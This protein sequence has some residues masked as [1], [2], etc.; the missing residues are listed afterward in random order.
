MTSRIDP[1]QYTVGWLAPMSLE[2]TPAI[3]ILEDHKEV[4][5]PDDKAIYHVGKIGPHFV[6]MAVSSMIGTAAASSVVENMCRS[7]PSIKH[8]LVVGIAGGIPHYGLDLQEQIVLGDVV[9]GV[10]L[11]NDGGVKHYEFGAWVE[12]GKLSVSGHLLHPSSTLLTAVNNLRSRHMLK[13][14]TRIPEFLHDLR[15]NIGDHELL[16]FHDPGEEHDLLFDDDYSHTYRAV[17]CEVLCDIERSRQRKDRGSKAARKEDTPLIHYG[18]I[19]SA[20]TLV[21][22]SE[23]RNSLYQDYGMICFEMESAGVLSHYQGLVIRGI[24]D[25]ADSHKNKN[26]QKYAA[27]TA[28]ACA[29]EI[30]L[31]VPAIHANQRSSGSRNVNAGSGLQNNTIGSG[32]QYNA[33]TRYFQHTRHHLDREIL[34]VIPAG[35]K[36]RIPVELP[37]HRNRYFKGREE[38]LQ[39]VSRLFWAKGPTGHRLDRQQI[40]LSG[41]SGT[42]K[43]QIALEYAYRYT[44]EYS[45]IFWINTK[46]EN[47]STKTYRRIARSLGLEVLN[48]TCK[49]SLLKAVDESSCAQCLRN[50][51]GQECNNRWLL[52]LDNYDDPASCDLE[53]LLPTQDFGHVL[54]TSCSPNSY[55]GCNRIE[56]PTGIKQHDAVD[57]LV[58]ILGKDIGPNENEDAVNLVEAVGRHPFAVTLIGAFLCKAPMPLNIYAQ[59]LENLDESLKPLQTVWQMSIQKLTAYAKHLFWLISLMGNEDIPKEFLLGGKGIIA[60]MTSDRAIYKALGELTSLSLVGQ[61]QDDSLYVHQ[62]LHEWARN[63]TENAKLENSRLVIDIIRST[64][65]FGDR[66]SA[67][68]CAYERR[69][70]PHINRCLELFNS[71]LS[72]GNSHLDYWNQKAAYD[73]ARVYTD[74]GYV[75]KSSL[76]YERSLMGIG[77]PDHPLVLEMMDSFGVN[78]RLQG[79]YDEALSWCRRAQDGIESQHGKESFEALTVA[80]NVAFI[81]K[82]QGKYTEA[83]AQY[84]EVLRQQEP[85]SALE[86][87]HQLACVLRD[88]GEYP[89]ALVQLEQVYKDRKKSLGEDHPNTLDTLHAI[90]T[91]LEK[92]GKYKEALEHHA[93]VLKEQKKSLGVGHY[94]TLDTMDSIASIQERLG[95]YDNALASYREVLKGLEDIFGEGQDHP[96]IASEYSGIADILLRQAKYDEAETT[97]KTA[98]SSFKRLDMGVRGEF[99]TATN[100]ARVLRDKGQ[101]QDA[102]KWCEIARKGLQK[103]GE[104]D[105][106]MLAARV[107]TAHIA[108]LRGMYGEALGM[109]QQ[110]V[111][112]YGK[113]YGE[114]HAETLKTRCRLG[115]VLNCQGQY[116]EALEQFEQ[117]VSGLTAAI[118]ADHHQTLVAVQGRADVLQQLGDYDQVLELCEHIQKTLGVILG[119]KHPQTLMAVYRYG[120]ACVSK[121]ENATGLGAIQRAMDGWKTVFGETHPYICMCL[122]DIGNAYKG[123]GESDRAINSYKKAI[124]GY[125]L[126]LSD[127]HPWTYR[128]QARLAGVLGASGPG[129]HEEAKRLYSTAILGLET[130]LGS[131]HPWTLAATD[132]KK[133]VF[134]Q[135]KVSNWIQIFQV[136]LALGLFGLW[137]LRPVDLWSFLELML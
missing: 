119:E 110:L 12:K 111:E 69:I 107:C 28:A 98:H 65:A 123:L 112:A 126:K 76:L 117:A 83:I 95:Q 130:T 81:Y 55:P 48:I 10:P 46:N 108:E 89:E 116:Q 29:K 79:K 54:I 39:Q 128:A 82:E 4:S 125:H 127:D 80:Y 132:D 30:L 102:V 42:G 118:G 45:A 35:D 74:L 73:L 50:W 129:H 15:A 5:I 90:A 56:V 44:E 20:N 134:P 78:L 92:Q 136:F 71:Q 97:Y 51:L 14:G 131:A 84:K 27:A 47:P 122:E 133:E 94:S 37:Y 104:N 62:L 3:A 53:K 13:E 25:Y 101:Y 121:G 137:V 93:L 17:S 113:K 115:S 40:A 2:L 88:S 105:E 114:N 24:S 36:Y 49:D 26:W 67:D 63:H 52:V 103:L 91:V 109:S 70:L 23:K 7:F 38:P 87:Q 96:W 72:S 59:D 85:S 86:T 99:P 106:H 43:S 77:D 41:S 57:L 16:D 66:R 33:D 11:N 19:G 31:L 100:I 61:K 1:T 58:R 64:F 34:S 124:D 120:S 68:K 18:T 6:V 22:S 75:Q 9:V 21:I 135:S 32:D 8:I 60:W